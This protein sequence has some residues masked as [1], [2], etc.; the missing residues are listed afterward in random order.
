MKLLIFNIKWLKTF[1]NMIKVYQV[2]RRYIML[3]MICL[4]LFVLGHLGV[5][6]SMLSVVHLFNNIHLFN[7]IPNIDH[8]LELEY[9]TGAR[10]WDTA[11]LHFGDRHWAVRVQGCSGAGT[12]R[13][14]V[15]ANIFEPE[16][17]S[18]NIV[19]HR[20]NADTAAFRQTSSGRGPIYYD[21]P[22]C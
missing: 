18:A 15:P 14:A 11:F 4:F 6:W 21:L 7:S 10:I 2:S 22:K 17:R 16:R 1:K 8:W 13:S 9:C 5:F 20:R 19:Y 3:I 12:R